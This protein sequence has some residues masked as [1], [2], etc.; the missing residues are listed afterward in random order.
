M[1][2]YAM[3]YLRVSD[4]RS[5][6]CQ[7]VLIIPFDEI[8]TNTLFVKLAQFDMKIEITRLIYIDNDAPKTRHG[9]IN[10]WL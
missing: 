3:H 6:S 4:I 2:F 7:Q 5:V 8:V 1:A 10:A 9:G